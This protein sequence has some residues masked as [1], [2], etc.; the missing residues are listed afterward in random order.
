MIELC[1][2]LCEPDTE[3]SSI[4]R[5]SDVA[6]LSEACASVVWYMYLTTGATPFYYVPET[7]RAGTKPWV[8]KTEADKFFK[9]KKGTISKT[10][11]GIYTGK[12]SLQ[13]LCD[14]EKHEM[15]SPRPYISLQLTY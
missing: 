9:T 4:P 10:K 7:F 12:W 8:N 14:I 5:F 15:V 6:K 1:G 11:A 13:D 2:E 3:P